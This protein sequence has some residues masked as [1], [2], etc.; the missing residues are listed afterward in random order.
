M[1]G[2]M[3]GDIPIIDEK[4]R[5][6]KFF[7]NYHVLFITSLT[8]IN[9][10]PH[11]ELDLVMNATFTDPN[12]SSAWFYQRWL[13]DKCIVTVRLWRAHIKKDMAIIV[14]DNNMLIKPVSPLLF[15]N[16]ENV[17]VN[18]QLYPDEKFAKLWIAK[19]D[20]SLAVLDYAKKAY[21]KLQETIY[22]LTYSESENA[23]IYKDNSYLYKQN[24]NDEQLNEQLSSYKQLSKME[25]NNKWAL[26]TGILL[27][28]KIDFTKFYNDILNNLTALSNVD[29][30]RSNYYKDL[31]KCIYIFIR[32]KKYNL[33][34]L[35]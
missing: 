8:I 3:S 10:I 12:D 35:Y 26:L 25:P 11:T 32:T 27:M 29:E 7:K 16:N 31:R 15:I 30:F 33:S 2:T 1:F 9:N 17:N 13:L 21:I 24:F 14:L 23:W 22:E 5:E 20:S 19:L 4:Y 18:W 6:G 28:K 34:F